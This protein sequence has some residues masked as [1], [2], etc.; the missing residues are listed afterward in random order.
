VGLRFVMVS[1]S[2]FLNFVICI[3]FLLDC[4]DFCGSVGF[5]KTDAIPIVSIEIWK[6]SDGDYVLAINWR[7]GPAITLEHTRSKSIRSARASLKD[8]RRAI[9]KLSCQSDIVFPVL[10]KIL[11]SLNNV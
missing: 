5:M 11:N 9:K 4:V 6:C 10:H 2:A 3:Y 7:G 1:F 8:Y